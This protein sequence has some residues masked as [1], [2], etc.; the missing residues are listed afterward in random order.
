MIIRANVTIAETVSVLFIMLFLYTGIS[1][2]SDYLVFKEQIA[3]SLILEKMAS[4]IAWGVPC[5]EL[6]VVLLL[7]IPRW[8]LKGLYASLLLMIL[9]TGYIL[10]ILTFDKTLPCSCGGV[11]ALLSWKQHIIFNSIFILLAVLGVAMQ[12]RVKKEN[13]IMLSDINKGYAI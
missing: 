11:I 13:K 1:K 9:F 10:A 4:Y 3:A 8:R 12:S 6:A 2:F 5:I 7:I